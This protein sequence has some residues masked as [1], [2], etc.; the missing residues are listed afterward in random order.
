MSS[1][2]ILVSLLLHLFTIV[3]L[4]YLYTRQKN[5]TSNQLNEEKMMRDIEEVF[6]G[7]LEE[8]KA[9][10]D[11]LL[12]YLTRKGN[13][14]SMKQDNHKEKDIQSVDEDWEE[15]PP[16]LYNPPI[17]NESKDVLEQSLR[18]RIYALYDQG[19]SID[20]IARELHCGR[21][22]V[23]LMLKFHPENE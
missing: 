6:T 7:Y 9:E 19:R 14:T 1:I 10:N 13:T 17:T 2:F 15:D 21:T 23:E 12:N 8:V 3:G 22:E 18:G 16:E 11:K 20:T 4:Y 5:S